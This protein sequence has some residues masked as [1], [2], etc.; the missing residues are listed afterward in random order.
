MKKI[1]NIAVI[2]HVD[3]GKST[4]VE[5][6]LDYA[7]SFTRANGQG[8]TLMDSNPLE[9]E[10]GITIYSKNCS[11]DFDDVRINIVD[12]PGHADFSSEVERIIQTVDTVILIVDASEGP[13]P[14]TRFVLSKALEQ[15]IVPIVL[16]NKIDK[17]DSRIV[18]VIDEVYE[19]F[20]S[21]N[22]TDAQ[23]EFPILYGVTK[24]RWITDSL[25]K[26]SNSL[27]PLID[28]ILDHTYTERN[29]SNAPFLFQVSTLAYDQYLGRIGIGRIFNGNVKRGDKVVWRKNDGTYENTSIK[30]ILH[31]EGVQPTHIDNAQTNEIVMI[32][33][34]PNLSIGE[35]LAGEDNE[36]ELPLIKIEEPTLSILIQVNSSPLAGTEGKYVTSRH[37]YERLL[38][39]LETN[40]GLK[41]ETTNNSDVF[42]VYGRG[43]LHLTILIETMRREG[44]EMEIS[45]P[46]ISYKE[47]EGILLEPY[48]KVF[49]NIPEVY[50]GSVMQSMHKREGKLEMMDINDNWIT[51]EWI[52]PLRLLLGFQEKFINMTKGEGT[53]IRSFHGYDKKQRSREKRVNGSMISNSEGQSM[54]YPMFHLQQRGEF[55]IGAQTKVYNGMVVGIASKSSD[56]AVNV[57]RNKRLNSFRGNGNGGKEEALKLK[58]PINLTLEY[59]LAYIDDSE[60]IEITPQSL[61]IRKKSHI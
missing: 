54:N 46:I 40:V 23:I 25:D 16:I 60:L 58:D 2:A 55:F 1:I 45:N 14:Q 4:L 21:L 18:E 50:S 27:K 47:V 31:Y 42:R 49:F 28:T 59:A 32:A 17:K 30:T 20:M 43:E 53:M 22:A 13:M 36:V 44:Y 38:R 19:L 3:A 48:E 15:G 8:L 24:E 34:I 61:R 37:L 26:K 11:L 52:V 5:G 35:V 6:L 41:V 57:I 56:I 51:Q 12:T 39:E 10:R 29:I 33:G 9:K 7:S